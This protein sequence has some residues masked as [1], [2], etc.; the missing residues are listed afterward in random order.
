M[1]TNL[2]SRRALAGALFAGLL[3]AAPPA[4]ADAGAPRTDDGGAGAAAT[5]PPPASNPHGS[6]PPGMRPVPED[7]IGEADDVPPGTVEVLVLDAN[8]QPVPNVE[9]TLGILAQSVAKGDSRRRVSARADGAGVARFGG[10][11][12]GS[13]IAYRAMV[14]REGATFS[15]PPSQ[16]PA[17]KGLRAKVHAY[18]VAQ[19]WPSDGVFARAFLYVEVKDDRVQIQQGFRV[20][21]TSTTAFVPNDTV[22]RLPEGFSAFAANQGMTDV[23]ADAVADQGVRF[24]GTFA[25][26][27]Q[28][29]EYRWQLPYSGEE[30]LDFDVDLL[31]ATLVAQVAAPAAK[32]MVLEVEGFVPALP[33]TDGNGQKVLVTE[34]QAKRG[35]EAKRSLHVTVK[36][37]PHE[38]PGKLVATGL[39]GLVVA[40]AVAFATRKRPAKGRASRAGLL[41]QRDAKVEEI[42]ALEREHAE[43][44]IGPKTYE[45]E[46]AARLRELALLLGEIEALGRT[47]RAGEKLP[48]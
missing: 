10:L 32:G 5:S 40:G 47:K 43:G 2:R 38:G 6:L 36:G 26:G 33:Q 29:I 23:G 22:L 46:R 9:V 12:T 17:E 19:G 11:E 15:A 48:K 13:G 28:V 21:N 1:T 27:S 8:E 16:L 34:W 44:A 37:L 18:D 3:A 30:R 31:P 25:P 35:D 41:A 20:V 42:R 39:S 45:R 4:G 7:D 14:L 24:R